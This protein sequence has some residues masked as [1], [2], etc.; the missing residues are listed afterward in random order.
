M[1]LTKKSL[2]ALILAAVAVL[3]LGGAT[4]AIAA[5]AILSGRVPGWPWGGPGGGWGGAARGRGVV[6]T[7]KSIDAS[8][9]VVTAGN[10]QTITMTVTSQTQVLLMPNRT[11]GKVTDIKVGD[12][13]QVQAGR[14][15][16]G[17]LEAQTITVGPLELRVAGQV[18]AVSG[19]DFSLQAGQNTQTIVTD[20]N[21]KFY[22]AGN[23]TGSLTDVKVGEF[24]TALVQK[25]SDG[26]LLAAQVVVGGQGFGRGLGG[27]MGQRVGGQVAGVDGAKVTVQVGQ[28]TQTFMTDANTKFYVAG[29]QTGSLAD[30]KTGEFVA[31]LVQKQSDGSLLAT[32]V[33]VGA[34]GSFGFRGFGFGMTG[35]RV[36]GQVTAVDGAKITV[37][38]GQSTQTI[39]TDANTKFYV[40]GNQTGS[41]ADVKTGEYVMALVQKQSDGSLLATQVAVGNNLGPGAGPMWNWSP[42]RG[43]GP[44]FPGRR[45]Q[46]VFPNT[47]S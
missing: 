33:E 19:S 39:V 42:R 10:S 16:G 38:V 18:T 21:T 17:G 7:V 9:L 31:A 4:L 47:N 32:Q 20:T 22:V 23:Q 30:V 12:T 27:I 25:Q 44:G 34:Q 14:T 3:G 5:P 13:V 36:G 15:T 35:E 11:A 43:P 2:I 26:S 6:G 40:A 37:Q 41:L 28:G 46:P 29:K 8:Q 45:P 24:V 1:K